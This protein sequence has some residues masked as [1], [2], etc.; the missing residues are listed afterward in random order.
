MDF[1][2]EQAANQPPVFLIYFL[3]YLAFFKKVCYNNCCQT[4]LIENLIR[5]LHISYIVYYSPYFVLFF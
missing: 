2:S 5:R 3:Q 4:N 1:I